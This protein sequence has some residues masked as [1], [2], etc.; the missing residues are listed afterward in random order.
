MRRSL[1]LKVSAE[2]IFRDSRLQGTAEVYYVT[3]TLFK[4][5]KLMSGLL[6]KHGSVVKSVWEMVDTSFVDPFSPDG[7][8]KPAKVPYC[9]V[10]GGRWPKLRVREIKK[11]IS[12][13]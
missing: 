8:A 7:D 11:T 1:K 12:G 9:R 4:P 10:T 5:K 13:H 3:P 2:T 6:R